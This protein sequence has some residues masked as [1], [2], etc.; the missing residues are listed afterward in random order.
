MMSRTTAAPG[1]DRRVRWTYDEFARLP[2]E[3]GVRHEVIADEL[4]VTPSPGTPHQ[5]ILAVFRAL[6]PFVREHGL[7]EVFLSPLDVLFAEGDYPV[8]DLAFVRRGREGVVTRRGIEATPD[9]R[10]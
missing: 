7:G 6:D 9:G 3:P 1:G 4:N 2:S 10:D 8:P 5:R